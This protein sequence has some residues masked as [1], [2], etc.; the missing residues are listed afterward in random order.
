V[1]KQAAVSFIV[2]QQPDFKSG[3]FYHKR[4]AAAMRKEAS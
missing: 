2:A 1:A 3:D 4:R